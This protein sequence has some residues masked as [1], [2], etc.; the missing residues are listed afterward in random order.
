MKEEK[1]R[2]R[3]VAGKAL[4][5]MV[6]VFHKNRYR[7]HFFIDHRKEKSK[8]RSHLYYTFRIYYVLLVD[9]CIRIAGFI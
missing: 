5:E 2:D 4:K 6:V 7:I 3:E 9:Y 8:R 1:Q